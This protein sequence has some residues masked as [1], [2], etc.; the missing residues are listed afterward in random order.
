[1]ARASSS[2]ECKVESASAKPLFM[3]KYSS[4]NSPLRSLH[5]IRRDGMMSIVDGMG[6]LGKGRNFL[7]FFLGSSF[8]LFFCSS[9]SAHLFSSSI[10][11]WSSLVACRALASSSTCLSQSCSSRLFCTL[12]MA[13]RH[14]A[15]SSCEM[16]QLLTRDCLVATTLC[17]VVQWS[18]FVGIGSVGHLVNVS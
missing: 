10:R 17:C 9:S 1:M 12:H 8:Q 16:V 4:Q 18:C 13:V 2:T 7:Q 14:V 5:I 11:C 6:V 3:K 15:G